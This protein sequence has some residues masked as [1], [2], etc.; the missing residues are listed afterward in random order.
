MNTIVC[1]TLNGAVSEYTRHHFHSVTASHGGGVDGLFAF[2]GDTDA[3]L[4]I[5]AELRMPV[6]LREN[7]LKQLIAMVYVSMQGEGSA[8]FTVFGPSQSWSY[9]FALRPSG[10]TR[11]QPGKGIRENY[12]GFGLSTP[13]GQDFTLDRVE[14][15]S[16]K[17]K[18]RRV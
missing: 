10:Q 2:G 17:S 11:C 1:N 18:T 16:V 12:L 9:P 4:P 8:E 3:G 6:T 7:T 13:D 15:L 14:I 5:T